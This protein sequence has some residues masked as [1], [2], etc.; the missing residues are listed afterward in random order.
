M[1]RKETISL[2]VTNA[3]SKRQWA[4][5]AHHDTLSRPTERVY[6]YSAV[7]V[8]CVKKSGNKIRRA[9]GK[10]DRDSEP[11]RRR[12]SEKIGDKTIY[13]KRGSTQDCLCRSHS[14]SEP[15]WRARKPESWK[16]AKIQS[17]QLF[18]PKMARTILV[19][20]QDRGFVDH[21]RLD[22]LRIG[23]V[24]GLWVTTPL[25]SAPTFSE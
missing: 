20:V 2:P 24:D 16:P 8:L 17:G 23:E 19:R 3:A 9:A 12:I 25:Q 10:P 1:R 21:L 4:S 14:T 7:R 11:G 13:C 22:V 6:S 18:L 5:N 15:V